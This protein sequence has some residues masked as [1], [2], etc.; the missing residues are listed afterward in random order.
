MLTLS[1]LCQNNEPEK[2]V[3]FK[4]IEWTELWDMIKDDM[5]GSDEADGSGERLPFFPTMKNMVLKYPGRR[6][7]S[8]LD[9]RTV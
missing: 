7:P 1:V 4:W 2:H 8:C 9:K 3:G 5:M 6:D